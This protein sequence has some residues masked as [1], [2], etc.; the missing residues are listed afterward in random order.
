MYDGDI[1]SNKDNPEHEIC[2]VNEIVIPTA[3]GGEAKYNDLAYAGLRLNSSKEWTNFSQFSA[4]FKTGVEI[5]KP[6]GTTGASNLF[7]EIAY[8]LLTDTKIGA[9]ELVGVS[10]VDETSMEDAA[11]FCYANRFF[12]DGTI[13]SKLNLRDFIFEH[14]GYCLLD[15][16]IIGGKFSLKPT[17]PIKGNGN[18]E[19]DK[20]RKPDIKC[21]F[22][23]GNIND[24]K[25]SFLNPEDRQPFKAAVV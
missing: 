12:W 21:L 8:A 3:I 14:A 19:I 9:G 10:S 15:F 7:P 24:L 6:D 13:S 1:N 25:V 16:T 11:K 18:F 22:T 2:F 20:N 5:K 4:Y 17:V 23:D